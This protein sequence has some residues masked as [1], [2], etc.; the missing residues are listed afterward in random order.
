VEYR[1]VATSDEN[2]GGAVRL[3][4]TALSSAYSFSGRRLVKQWVE[5]VQP[6]VVHVHNTFPLLSPSIFHELRSIGAPSVLTLHNYRLICANALLLRDAQVCENCVSH[7]PFSAIKYRCYKSSLLGSSVQVQTRIVH[8]FLKTYQQKVDAIIVLSDFAKSLFIRHGLPEKLLHV[9]PNFVSRPIVQRDKIP[10]RFVFVGKIVGE[11][12]VDR[13]L[14]A[15]KRLDLNTAELVIIGDGPF[16]SELESQYKQVKNVQWRGWLS[17]E[18]V[19]DVVAGASWLVMSS[20]W[21]EGFPMVLP[22]A[23]TASTPAIVPNL[24]A[25]P[26]VVG[27]GKRGLIYENSIEGLIQAFRRALDTS[28]EKYEFL[29]NACRDAVRNEYSE[30]QN[31]K[32]LIEI[33]TQAI[34]HSKS[35]L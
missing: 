22:E 27:N 15:W 28:A 26:E 5:E 25:M 2:T 17:A 32:T 16:K 20:V 13:L 9:K 8:D 29:Q 14:E 3:L 34:E 4:K 33:Y 18:E 11:K 35:H 1:S 24:G 30:S 21:Y 7:S 19:G 10:N 12:A 31:L 23:F 6:D